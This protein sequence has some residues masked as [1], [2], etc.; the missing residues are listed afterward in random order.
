MAF[1]S[2]HWEF[3]STLIRADFSL[4]GHF[5]DTRRIVGA[6]L[7]FFFRRSRFHGTGMD[8]WM[9]ARMNGDGENPV[10]SVGGGK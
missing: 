8:G 4:L 9:D 2:M 5:F 10:G 7:L 6:S 3:S 1:F